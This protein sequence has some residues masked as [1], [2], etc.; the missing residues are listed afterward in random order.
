MVALTEER[1]LRALAALNILDTPREERFD[2][3]VRLAQRMFDVP[4]AM[5]SLIDQD[6]Q[7]NKAEV[8]LGHR[9]D[10]PR[11]TSM[12]DHTIR[13][14]EALVVTDPVHDPRFASYP[15][16]AAEGGVRF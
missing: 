10:V 4:M 13:G 8:G 7:W 16:V 14:D 5:V 9:D 6:R 1:R 11:S 15:G 12:C 3:L 2:R